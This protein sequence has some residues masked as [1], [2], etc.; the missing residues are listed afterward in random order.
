MGQFLFLLKGKWTLTRTAA[1][2]AHPYMHFHRLTN[3]VWLK[4]SFTRAPIRIDSGR[5]PSLRDARVRRRSRHA[6]E[7]GPSIQPKSFRTH[8]PPLAMK[9]LLCVIQCCKKSVLTQNIKCASKLDSTWRSVF[10]SVW[11]QRNRFPLFW[12]K[13]QFVLSLNQEV[14]CDS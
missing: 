10:E 3:N 7:R 9:P 4:S 5:Q 8:P 12:L 6:A 13:S 2:P 11:N 14:G 1:S